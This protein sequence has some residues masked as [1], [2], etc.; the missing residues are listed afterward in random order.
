MNYLIRLLR[1]SPYDCE[2]YCSRNN[3]NWVLVAIFKDLAF[4]EEHFPNAS[5]F[6]G[7]N[8]ACEC[9]GPLDRDCWECITLEEERIYASL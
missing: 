9:V 4:A 5:V 3:A 7:H 1:K 2:V 6:T 8:Q